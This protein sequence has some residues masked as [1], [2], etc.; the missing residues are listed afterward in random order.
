MRSDD[1]ETGR[2]ISACEGR[3]YNRIAESVKRTVILFGGT[4]DPPHIGHLTM[5]QLA[6]EQTGAKEVWFVPAPTPPHKLNEKIHTLY[7]RTQMVESLVTS[8]VHLKVVPIENQLPAPSYTVDTIRA[9]QQWFPDI[10]FKLL[11]GGDSLG[12][13]PTWHEASELVRMVEF[14]VAART[15]YPYEETL[16]SVARKLPGIKAER[17][18]MP[19]LDVSSTWIRERLNHG[20]P[21]CDLLP[22]NVLRIWMDEVKAYPE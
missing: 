17:I 7:H 18:E 15:G 3:A 19:I 16:Q 11:I 14:L 2:S 5:A 20:L 12:H 8:Y 13:L 9:C 6:Y 1:W 21:V 22:E 4:F 10:H